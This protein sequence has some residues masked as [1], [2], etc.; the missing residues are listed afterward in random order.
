MFNE[1]TGW[2][3]NIEKPRILFYQFGGFLIIVS[4]YRFSNYLDFETTLDILNIIASWLLFIFGSIICHSTWTKWF[5]KIFIPKTKAK[6]AP[7]NSFNLSISENHLKLLFDRLIK[8]NF[9]EEKRT[10]FMSFKKVLLENRNNKDIIYFNLDAGGA[11]EFY[12]LLSEK[13]PKNSLKFF[14]INLFFY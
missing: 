3:K 10:S 13:Y 4:F 14:K 9:I 2:D 12:Q 8:F 5:K 7:K 1:K 11:R 6:L